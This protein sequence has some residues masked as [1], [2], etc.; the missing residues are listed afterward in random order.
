[1]DDYLVSEKIN[2][3]R[4]FYP[5]KKYKN[6]PVLSPGKPWEGLRAYLY[7]TVLPSEDGRGYRMWYQVY[8]EKGNFSGLRGYVNAYATSKDGINWVKPNLGIFEWNGSTE[9]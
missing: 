7:G 1:M 4:T 2:V 9:N 8:N 5:F 3:V 6:N